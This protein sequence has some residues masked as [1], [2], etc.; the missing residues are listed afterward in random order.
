MVAESNTRFLSKL[1]FKT[2]RDVF[3]ELSYA[4]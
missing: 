3:Y 2:F 4:T 1:G